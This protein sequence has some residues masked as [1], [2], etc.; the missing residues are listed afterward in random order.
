MTTTYRAEAVLT[1]RGWWVVSVPDVR[2]VHTQGRT[3][4]EARYM[5]RDALALMLDVDIA[6]VEV[7][8][9]PVLEGHAEHVIEEITAAR[10]ERERA[11]KAEQDMLRTAA[12]TLTGAG[13]SARDA[14]ALLGVSNKRIYQLV[15]AQS[16]AA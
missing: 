8:L 13:V 10:A 12:L 9:V 4:D 7:D 16:V 1:E 3:W 2:G 15:G 5:A 14:G 11:A 6:Q